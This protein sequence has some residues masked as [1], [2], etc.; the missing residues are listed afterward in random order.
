MCRSA[1]EALIVSHIIAIKGTLT[2]W[3]VAPNLLAST[4]KKS[5]RLRLPQLN[6]DWNSTTRNHSVCR[7]C[8]RYDITRSLWIWLGL[9]TPTKLKPWLERQIRRVISPQQSQF[10]SSGTKLGLSCHS[11]I[12]P[13]CPILWRV[14]LKYAIYRY[15]KLL[16]PWRNSRATRG[17]GP[18]TP[19]AA[20]ELRPRKER[21]GH[22][23][24]KTWGLSKHGE[25][26][27]WDEQSR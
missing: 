9:K 5:C 7:V 6:F 13:L 2:S 15:Q 3:C 1:C 10:A 16:V 8:H 23:M 17:A 12:M 4:S 24:K 20:D 14:L 19:T 18:A 27:P 26:Q 11:A 22:G 25:C 21:F